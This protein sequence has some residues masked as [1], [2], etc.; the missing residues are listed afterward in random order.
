MAAAERAP[1]TSTDLPAVQAD[2]RLALPW[3]DTLLARAQT[4]AGAHAL[5][6]HGPGGSGHFEAALLLAQTLLCDAPVSTPVP[7]ACGQCTSCRLVR[8]RAHPDLRLVLPYAL[9]SPMGWTDDEDARAG[10]PEG[11]AKPSKEL[12]IKQIRSAIDWCQQTSGRGRGKVLVLHPADALNTTSANALLKTLEEPPGRLRILLTSVDPERLLPT[13]RSR[14]QRLP[15]AL[16]PPDAAR[17]SM[18]SSAT[19][20]SESVPISTQQAF[21]A[22]ASTA[23]SSAPPAFVLISMSFGPPSPRWKS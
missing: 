20:P 4:L 16:P 8:T 6:L 22:C 13:V 10:E 18:A 21:C 5:L 15:L 12:R 1:A 23:L 7:R 9:R 14:C 17:S 3:L 2:G 19:G 11:G